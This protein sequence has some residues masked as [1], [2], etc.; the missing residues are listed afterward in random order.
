MEKNGNK[1]NEWTW[2][3]NDRRNWQEQ[4]MKREWGT[5]WAAENTHQEMM[6]IKKKH[7][8]ELIASEMNWKESFRLTRKT[9]IQTTWWVKLDSIERMSNATQEERRWKSRTKKN[10]RRIRD[11]EQEMKS[12]GWRAR[13]EEQGIWSSP[14]NRASKRTFRTKQM[15]WWVRD[16]PLLWFP[17]QQHYHERQ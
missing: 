11:E 12:K 2:K 3:S 1:I 8:N 5:D 13:D 9:W 6:K 10:K 17:L 16:S 4:E 7:E 14:R 15:K